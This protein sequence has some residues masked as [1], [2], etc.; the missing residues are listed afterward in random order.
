MLLLTSRRLATTVLSGRA[1]KKVRRAGWGDVVA[2][3]TDVRN[4][5]AC[6]R[7]VVSEA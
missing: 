3:A 6:P 7:L 2:I 4:M 5:P 1:M